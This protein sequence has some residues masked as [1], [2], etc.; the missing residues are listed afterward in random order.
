MG[1]PAPDMVDVLKNVDRKTR[2]SIRALQAVYAVLIVVAVGFGILQ[3]DPVERAALGA[4]VVAFVLVVVTQ[5]LRFRAYS[6]TYLG[7]PPV[8]YLHRARKRMRVFTVRTWLALP[9]WL[10]IDVGLC[11]LIYAAS[12]HLPIPV[13]HAIVGLQGLL[14]GAVALDFWSEYLVWKRIHAP[15]VVEIDRMLGEIEASLATEG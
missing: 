3:D 11:L 2:L 9:T 7:V 12:E 10:L 5:Q 8:E 4:F 14:V 6:E 13:A 15:V 1:K